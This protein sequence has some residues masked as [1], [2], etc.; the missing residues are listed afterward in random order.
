MRSQNT[1]NTIQ[2]DL[3]IIPNTKN[4]QILLNSTSLKLLTYNYLLPLK[5]RWFYEKGKFTSLDTI[6]GVAVLCRETVRRYGTVLYYMHNTS[7]IAVFK[8]NQAAKYGNPGVLVL[9]QGEWGSVDPQRRAVR[10]REDSRWCSV[11]LN[12]RG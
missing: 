8:A 4:T 1:L 3:E 6:P 7:G 10:S 11:W 5:N 9:H 2:M 12:S